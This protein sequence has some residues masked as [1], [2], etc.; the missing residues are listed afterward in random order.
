MYELLYIVPAIYAEDELKNVMAK[1][2]ALLKEAGAEAVKS[3]NAGKLKFAYSI[4]KHTAGFYILAH[5]NALGDALKNINRALKL[6]KDILRFMLTK[7]LKAKA[8]VKLKEFTEIEPSER[9]FQPRQ[10]PVVRDRDKD[11]IKLED[12]DKKLDILLEKD[13]V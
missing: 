5:F 4:K 12:M 8:D 7:Q 10:A 1:T 9:K 6:E 11:K 2:E 3:E 13:I